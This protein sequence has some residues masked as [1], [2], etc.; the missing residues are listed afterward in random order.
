MPELPDVEGFKRV[1]A[2]RALRKTI[3]RVVVSDAR[4]LDKLPA[5]ALAAR[6]KGA[7]LVS[8][9]RHGKHLMAKIDRG[10]WLT[11]HFGLTGALHFVRSADREPPFTRVRLDFAGGGCLAYTNKRMLGRVGLVEDAAD[12]IA[13]EEL[14][15]DALDRRFDFRAFQAAVHGSK[16]GVKSVLMDQQI[17]A[18]VG[19]IYSD[20]ILFQ[21]RINPATRIDKLATREQ[22]R[23]FAQMRKVLKTAVA[24]GAG[25]EQFV[26]RLP[27]GAMLPERKPGGRCP[28]CRSPLKVF[29]V[30]GRTGYCCPR[31][32]NC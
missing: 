29:K 21:A 8:A 13:E 1:L 27:K 26:D 4:I 2:R 20:E 7:K 30:A 15:P 31:C 19:N 32:Q 16:R 10:G 23:L 11:L 6:L 28:R 25:S 5:R 18:G 3:D 17:I 12:F 14:G 22:K 24:R 9:R